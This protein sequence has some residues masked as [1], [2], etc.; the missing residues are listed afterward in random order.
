MLFQWLSSQVFFFHS[1]ETMH[2]GPEVRNINTVFVPT[3]N[4]VGSLCLRQDSQ[5]HFS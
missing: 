2:E 4:C 1:D 3:K 5:F